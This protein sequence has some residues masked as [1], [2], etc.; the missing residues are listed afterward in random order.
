[1]EWEYNRMER[2]KELVETLQR[3]SLAYYQE[4]REVMSN[5]E[6][7]ELYD[8]LLNLEK[9]SGVILS[10]SPTVQVGYELLSEL[11]REKHETPMLSLDK[12]K[13]IEELASWLG[14][15]N[16]LLS[17]KMDGLTIVLTYKEGKLVKAV[18]RGNGEEG[19]VVTSNARNFVNIPLSIP[20][21][22]ELILRGEAVIGYSDFARMNDALPVEEEKY[23]NPRNLCSGSVRQLNSGVTAKRNVRF[24]AFQLV[25]AEG[26]DFEN[27]RARQLS[28][29][30]EQGFDVVYF[31]PVSADNVASAVISFGGMVTENDLPSDGLVLLYDDI[32]YGQSLGRTAKF[33]RDSIAFK[34]TDELA[35]T[36]LR[37]IEWSPSRTGLINPVAVFEPVALEGTTVSRASV[38][39]LNILEDLQLGEGDRITVYKANMIIPQVADNL[40]RSGC[41]KP[42]V[43]CPVCGGKTQIHQTGET[44]SLYCMNP[45]CQVKKI[46]S[47]ALFVSRDALNI[48]GLSEVTLEKWIGAGL[49]HSFGDIFH[50]EEKK[51]TIV[52]MEGFGEKSFLRLQKAIEQAKTTTLPRLLYGL[53]IAGIGAANAKLLCRA[54]DHDLEKIRQADKEELMRVDGIGEVLAEGIWEY[55]ADEKKQEQLDRLLT[56]LTLEKPDGEKKRP[57]MG[58]VI[59]ITGSL[60]HFANRQELQEKIEEA[61]GKVTGS[62][63][64]K[65][66]CLINNNPDSISSKN[67]KARELN[68]PIYSEEEFLKHL[69]E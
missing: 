4:S 31:V 54:F 10:G 3:A 1:M 51:E 14:D 25:K 52:A 53:G 29:L 37:E 42:P 44:K 26:I 38:H 21:W 16:G 63:T 43:T 55:F 11:P 13:D 41:A 67:R 47:F 46:K 6:Y 9:E 30:G 7:D 34:W 23:K 69:E 28:W 15:Q 66:T 2:M 61:G 48:D 58:Q 18:T 56:I 20:Y 12:T 57:L 59:V 64:A 8:E 27:S 40:T 62:V 5:R 33:P 32:A 60:N 36:T 39:N 19:E 35:E 50:L 49:I 68:I 45:D 65:T 22:G 17:W 24:Y